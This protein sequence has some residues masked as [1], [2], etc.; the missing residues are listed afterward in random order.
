MRQLTVP[1]VGLFATAL[2]YDRHSLLDWGGSGRPIILLAGGGDTDHVF[3]G[4][5]P[6]L[7]SLTH[8]HVYAITRRG[9][10]AS[11]YKA[12]DDPA[13]RL[14]EDVLSVIESL[15]LERPILAGHS[16]AGAEMSWIASNHPDRVAGLSILRPDTHTP[17]TTATEQVLSTWKVNTAPPPAIYPAT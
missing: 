14:G 1:A 9:F 15:K 7:R 4:F 13:D 17:S 8:L 6:K 5:A 16:I 3:D 10:G 12:T 2:S 11:G